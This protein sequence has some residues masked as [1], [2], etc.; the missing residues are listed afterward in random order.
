ME[1]PIRRALI[2]VFHKEGLAP[3]VDR[4]HAHG[5]EIL[6]TGGTQ[7]AIEALGAPVTPVESVTQTAEMLGGRV[8]TLH[9]M[10]FGGI[11]A[12]RDFGPDDVDV[13]DHG[14]GPIDLVIVDLYP[15]EET[16]AS[17]A[18]EDEIIEKIDIGGIALIR[19]AAK[20]FRD[21]VCIPSRDQYGDLVAALGEGITTSLDFR[22]NMA[23][24]AFGVSSGYDAAIGRW[25]RE[26]GNPEVLSVLE[27]TS[28]ALRYG[29][30]P[31]QPGAFYGDLD[32]LFTQHNGK[33][34]SYN[35]LLDV[36]AAVQLMAEFKDDAPTVAILK[37]NNACG[38]ATR[39][40]LSTAYADALAG[41]PISAFGGVVIM[42][43]PLDIDTAEALHT[44]F[45]E[46]VIAPSFAPEALALLSGKK[47]RILLQQQRWPSAGKLVR[48]ALGGYLVQQPDDQIEGAGAFT[49]V[50]Q[51]APTDAQTEDLAFA[52]KLAKHTRSNTI[53]L[54]KG[55]QLLASGT[56]QTSRVDALNQAIDKAGR[57]GFS[58]EGASMASDAF[59]P[60]PDCVEIADKAGIAAVVQPGGSIK[61][62][63]SIAY[64]DAHGM[65]MV[66]TGVRHFR[67]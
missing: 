63:E 38:L 27:T 19:A 26:G 52:L 40:V 65:A 12:R 36:D 45:C 44:L 10:V 61:D 43:R 8:K 4:L 67:H 42:N 66:T 15:F 58:L 59:F 9:P 41:D 50:T 56:G 34:L 62:G 6:S 64:C 23:G 49:C 30:N 54:A 39:E 1:R 47:N 51:V 21:V 48:S 55:G 17:G 60:F 25:V 7:R 33:A 20:N 53:V 14:I 24:A 28:T 35:N 13:A 11:L 32:G 5:V 46:V 18:E 22:R 37:H 16:L 29:E 31:H 2:S 3:I 57:M